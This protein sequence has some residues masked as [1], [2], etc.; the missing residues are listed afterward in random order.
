MLAIWLA[1][2]KRLGI[3]EV[4]INLHA[5]ASVVRN[6]LR[7]HADRDVLLNVVEEARL[8]GSAGILRAN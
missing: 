6:F 5:H 7:N 2:C 4:S 1:F 3:R 8:V